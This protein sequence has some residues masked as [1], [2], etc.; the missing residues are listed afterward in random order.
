MTACAQATGASEQLLELCLVGMLA[1]L[2]ARRYFVRKLCDLGQSSGATLKESRESCVMTRSLTSPP[3]G[4]DD[5][6]N[7]ADEVVD[8]NELSAR[9][10]VFFTSPHLIFHLLASSQLF[11]TRLGD[12]K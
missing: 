12:R 7:G 5:Q 4:H 3:P 1:R 10:D 8:S 11:L 6:G 2:R 9:T